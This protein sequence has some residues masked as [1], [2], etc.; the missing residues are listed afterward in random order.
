MLDV[1]L[2][3]SLLFLLLSLLLNSQYLARLSKFTIGTTRSS[4]INEKIISSKDRQRRRDN[5]SRVHTHTR[6]RARAHTHTQIPCWFFSSPGVLGWVER[7]ETQSS[8][9]A[10]PLW[11]EPGLNSGISV[12]ELISTLKKKKLNAGWV[13][14]KIF[15]K[16]RKK[17]TFPPKA[18]HT[19]RRKTPTIE[20]GEATGCRPQ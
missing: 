16:Q 3:L 20:R 18:P 15:F 14:K 7:K 2:L 12:R 6:A 5:Q 1:V 9:L 13:L 4:V 17:E 19:R 8:E 11:T 10:E